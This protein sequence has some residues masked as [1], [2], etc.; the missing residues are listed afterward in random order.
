MLCKFYASKIC[1]KEDPTVLLDAQNIY[2]CCVL[3]DA[4]SAK[5]QVKCTHSQ[6]HHIYQNNPYK[7]Y[8]E[9]SYV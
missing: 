9:A 3:Q 1:L 6:V 8:V 5:L 7:E 2:F 4:L